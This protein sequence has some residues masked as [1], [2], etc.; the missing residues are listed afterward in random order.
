MTRAKWA[1]VLV[2][3]LALSVAGAVLGLWRAEGQV[4]LPS[5]VAATG[6][7]LVAL[8]VVQK[9]GETRYEVYLLDTVKGSIWLKSQGPRVEFVRV[10]SVDKATEPVR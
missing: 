8:P 10:P 2:A 6:F 5:T 9:D 3:V 7:Q 4:S 1:V